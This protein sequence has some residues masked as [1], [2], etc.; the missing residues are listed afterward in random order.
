MTSRKAEPIPARM[1]VARAQVKVPAPGP[2]R[3]SDRA[4]PRSDQK[5]LADL[6]VKLSDPDYMN[7]AILRIATVLSSRLTLR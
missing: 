3:A 4:S 1:A 5:R 2:R 7:G 6:K